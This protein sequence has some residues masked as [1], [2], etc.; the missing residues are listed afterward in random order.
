MEAVACP[1]MAVQ[2]AVGAGS[3]IAVE[4]PR[5]TKDGD[6]ALEEKK[7]RWSCTK[8]RWQVVRDALVDVEAEAEVAAAAFPSLSL[9][10]T[11]GSSARAPCALSALVRFWQALPIWNRLLWSWASSLMLMPQHHHHL[12]AS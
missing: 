3:E 7:D 10:H 6:G 8:K 9:A 1:E 5:T 11:G 12:A 2:V 4:G